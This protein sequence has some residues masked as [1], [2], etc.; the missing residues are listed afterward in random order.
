[1]KNHNFGKCHH[2]QI[3]KGFQLTVPRL[4]FSDVTLCA[5]GCHMEAV[6]RPRDLLP[7]V[8]CEKIAAIRDLTM[9]IRDMGYE[10][11]YHMI[12]CNHCY[13]SIY[14]S[15][16]QFGLVWEWGICW[17]ITPVDGCYIG[18]IMFSGWVMGYMNSWGTPRSPKLLSCS[19]EMCTPMANSLQR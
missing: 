5:F 10:W 8:R 6:R 9:K 16:I 13:N 17:H 18:K 1:M 4:S 14:I 15:Y 11:G 7:G 12:P 3:P 2:F 19:K